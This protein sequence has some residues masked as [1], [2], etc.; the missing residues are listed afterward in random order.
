MAILRRGYGVQEKIVISNN[1]LIPKLAKEL[2]MEK[3]SIVIDDDIIKY[4]VEKFTGEE[5]GV[6]NL[7]RCLEVVYSKLNLYYLMGNGTKLLEKILL[8]I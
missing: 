3:D 6:R 5:K 4:L 8:K 7:K 1:Y 2:N